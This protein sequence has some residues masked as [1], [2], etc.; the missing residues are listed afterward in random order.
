MKLTNKHDRTL[1]V[2]G[3]TAS[4]ILQPGESFDITEDD[5]KAINE[6]KTAKLW[7]DKK[8]LV[9][10]G[11]KNTDENKEKAVAK[12]L[13]SGKYDVFV[14]DKKISEKTLEK[15]EAEKFVADYNASN[16]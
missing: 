6:N 14:N 2:P 5:L 12:H 10:G 1:G 13:G 4:I 9:L 7:L 16:S 8:I 3:A 11:V 15:E